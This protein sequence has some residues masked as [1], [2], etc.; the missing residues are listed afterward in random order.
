MTVSD[1]D[2]GM[3]PSVLLLFVAVRRTVRDTGGNKLGASAYEYVSAVGVSARKSLGVLHY[4]V[5]PLY[6]AK[7]A[8]NV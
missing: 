7:W 2:D 6:A 8:L 1:F 5:V 4:L 3:F